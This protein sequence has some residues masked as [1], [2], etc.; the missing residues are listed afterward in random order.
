M[1]KQEK[2]VAVKIMDG[3]RIIFQLKQ[4]VIELSNTTIN[5]NNYW[6]LREDEEILEKELN[7]RLGEA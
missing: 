2:M 7:S 3:S 4:T 1:T 5:D 6:E